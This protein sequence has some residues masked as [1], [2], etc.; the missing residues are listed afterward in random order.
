MYTLTVSLG[1]YTFLHV[2]DFLEWMMLYSI[3]MVYYVKNDIAKHGFYIKMIMIVFTCRI[4]KMFTSIGR[5][6]WETFTFIGIM[7]SLDYREAELFS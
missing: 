5:H 6:Y 4:A 3:K 2:N 7:Y 1:V